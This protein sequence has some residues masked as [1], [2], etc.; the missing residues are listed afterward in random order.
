MFSSRNQY[1]HRLILEQHAP[2]N[3]PPPPHSHQPNI[4]LCPA[5]VEAH[6]AAAAW[7]GLGVHHPQAGFNAT[8]NHPLAITMNQP[9]NQFP[10]VVGAVGGQAPNGGCGAESPVNTPELMDFNQ[11]ATNGAQSSISSQVPPVQIAD[12]VS[13]ISP[14]DV[15]AAVNDPSHAHI[16]H[17]VHQHHYHNHARNPI[18]PFPGYHYMVSWNGWVT[19]VSLFLSYRFRGPNS[20]PY[21]NL[22]LIIRSTFL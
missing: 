3:V 11:Y 13:G 9:L 20:Y 22:F 18:P 16:H 4:P 2:V 15:I 19:L 6:L 8:L 7:T 14:H 21:R 17:H 5:L 10:T 12:Q 1:L